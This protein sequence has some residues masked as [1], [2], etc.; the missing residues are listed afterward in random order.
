MRSDLAPT[1]PL[2]LCATSLNATELNNLLYMF[3]R[4]GLGFDGTPLRGEPRNKDIQRMMTLL[5]PPLS[6]ASII[7]T[8]MDFAE[9]QY[10]HG[11]WGGARKDAEEA[12][13]RLY[14]QF[15]MLP[16]GIRNDL[17]DDRDEVW[18]L[19]KN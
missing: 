11:R 4:Y 18:G 5:R 6:K 9:S 12:L 13:G 2:V 7:A 10:E 1:E 14:E 15:F 19:G 3:L 16:Y 8:V 17:G